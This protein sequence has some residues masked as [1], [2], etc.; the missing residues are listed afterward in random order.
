M[1]QLIREYKD[2]DLIDVMAVWEAASAQ[3]HPFLPTE[4]VDGIR[5]AIPKLYLP[6]AETWVVEYEAQLVGFISLLG[7][8]VGAV[9]VFPE[10][11]GQGLG[12]TLMSKAE[13]L[14]GQLEVEVFSKNV[15]GC[16]FYRK[17]GFVQ[18]DKKLHDPTGLELLRLRTAEK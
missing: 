3:A 5:D 13:E 18:I 7:N 1:S 16:K 17:Y 8:E 11:Q 6:N 2:A 12:L 4:F 15:I 9:F 14:K 10:Y